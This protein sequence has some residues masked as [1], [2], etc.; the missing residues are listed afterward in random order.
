MTVTDIAT[1]VLATGKYVFY[2]TPESVRNTM[3]EDGDDPFDRPPSMATWDAN[4]ILRDDLV[5]VDYWGMALDHISDAGK[6]DEN[7]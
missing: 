1:H 5:L 7:K 6:K 4:L 2:A 3:P